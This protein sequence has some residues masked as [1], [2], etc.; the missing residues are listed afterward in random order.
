MDAP[1]DPVLIPYIRTSETTH[2][3]DVLRFDDLEMTATMFNRLVIA[4][5][6]GRFT[7]LIMNGC[8]YDDNAL[9]TFILRLPTCNKLVRLEISMCPVKDV[10]L[11][12]MASVL[13]QTTLVQLGLG[14]IFADA[15]KLIDLINVIGEE[16]CKIATLI[17]C[18]KGIT[19]S[20]TI[21]LAA[22]LS[23]ESS[24][25]RVLR[26]ANSTMGRDG[27]L[28][29][30]SA[31]QGNKVLK[32]LCV[33][34]AG[35]PADLVADVARAL[36]DHVT[37]FIAG[38]QD[39][40]TEDALGAMCD[41]IRRN[42]IKYFGIPYTSFGPA[43]TVARIAAAVRD[44]PYVNG[45]SFVDAH[46][47][48][49]EAAWEFVR[50]VGPHRRLKEL[51][52]EGAPRVTDACRAGTQTRLDSYHTKHAQILCLLTQGVMFKPK[53]SASAFCRLMTIDMVKLLHAYLPQ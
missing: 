43:D 37:V 14:T 46:I 11:E 35:I 45:V 44:S 34:S 24:P 30:I 50:I 7:M 17:L 18:G 47:C 6:T 10:H 39:G 48:T 49:D 13:N 23:S 9:V 3:S 25:I 8:F 5:T 26:I 53:Y 19:T 31:L 16:G 42:K 36:A 21:R 1:V 32:Y 22:V 2:K 12:A 38:G 40:L 15:T 27:A 52:M 29:L 33:A 4:F 51:R 20:V 28:A 41:L